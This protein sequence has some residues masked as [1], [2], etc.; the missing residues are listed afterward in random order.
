MRLNGLAVIGFFLLVFMPSTSLWSNLGL[1]EASSQ[2]WMLTAAAGLTGLLTFSQRKSLTVA[3][4]LVMAMGIIGVFSSRLYLGLALVL[5]FAVCLASR[6]LASKSRKI[7]IASI[8]ALGTVIGVIGV[9]GVEST[10]NEDTAF[11]FDSLPRNVTAEPL[12]VDGLPSTTADLLPDNVS[13]NE[14][15]MTGVITGLRQVVDVGSPIKYVGIAKTQRDRLRLN[16]G[17]AIHPAACEITTLEIEFTCE[18]TR[19]PGAVW[20]VLTQP[21]WPYSEAESAESIAASVEN[22]LWLMAITLTVFVA[23]VRSF[24]LPS[25]VVALIAYLA[26]LSL[27]MGLLEGNLGTAFRHKSSLLWAISLVLAL[28]STQ[29]SWISR[30]RRDLRDYFVRP[31][32]TRIIRK[33]QK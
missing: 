31:F 12:E 19:L 14:S 21:L 2:F 22:W 32:L 16:A 27:G 4:A 33:L 17:S 13:Q 11:A 3:C 24:L 28:A 5:G 7:L 26:L 29:A 9:R 1:R 18:I 10:L 20:Q 6:P 8:L 23:A 15:W 25:L 30:L